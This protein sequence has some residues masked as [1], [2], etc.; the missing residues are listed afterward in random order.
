[1]EKGTEDNSRNPRNS[2]CVVSSHPKSGSAT[3][4][5]S[6][7]YYYVFCFLGSPA[8]TPALALSITTE[9]LSWAVVEVCG[10]GLVGVNVQALML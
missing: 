1:M 2:T 8:W 9:P 6:V 10:G 3:R 5:Y 4:E 7:N